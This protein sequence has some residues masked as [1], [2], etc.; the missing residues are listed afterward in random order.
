[1]VRRYREGA[2]MNALARM[3]DVHVPWLRHAFIKWNVPLRDP[4]EANRP[5]GA[6]P[7]REVHSV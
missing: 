7:V 5:Q 1:M 6:P 3:Y 4:A 2:S